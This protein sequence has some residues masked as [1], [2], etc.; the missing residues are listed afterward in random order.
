M[1][2]RSVLN[3]I[4]EFVTRIFQWI[5]RAIGMFVAWLCWPFV[6]AGR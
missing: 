3:P 4:V 5:G 1:K 2:G 6:L